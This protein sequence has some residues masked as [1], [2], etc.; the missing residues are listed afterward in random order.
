VISIISFARWITQRP[1]A[2]LAQVSPKMGST[3]A[4]GGDRSGRVRKLKRRQRQEPMGS[5]NLSN[6]FDTYLRELTPPRRKWLTP[7]MQEQ[8]RRR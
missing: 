1:S 8:S 5:P 3:G 2:V 4:S 6:F 7:A